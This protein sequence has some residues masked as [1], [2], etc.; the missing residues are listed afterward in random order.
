[1]TRVVVDRVAAVLY[2]TRE[3]GPLGAQVVQRLTKRASRHHAVQ[4]LAQFPAFLV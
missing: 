3:L 1:M 2:V 4:V